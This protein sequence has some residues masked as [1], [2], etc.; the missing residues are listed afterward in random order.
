MQYCIGCV[1][2]VLYFTIAILVWSIALEYWSIGVLKYWSIASVRG[3]E[4][5]YWFG[6][7]EYWIIVLGIGL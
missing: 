7:F 3:L 4:W 1:E 6:V 5:Q 2:R